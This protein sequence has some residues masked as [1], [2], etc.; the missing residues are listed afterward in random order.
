MKDGATSFTRIVKGR[1]VKVAP[2]LVAVTVY[3][4]SARLVVGVPVILPVLML[5]F[6]PV[7][8]AAEILYVI[9]P[10]PDVAGLGPISVKRLF[11]VPIEEEE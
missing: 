8:S 1:Q 10:V 4:V 11:T 3:D 2:V 5:K 9:M 6:I 7:G